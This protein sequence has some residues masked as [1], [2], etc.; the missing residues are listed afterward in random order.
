MSAIVLTEE[1]LVRRVIELNCPC[2]FE[3]LYKAY[4]NLVRAAL[5]RRLHGLSSAVVEEFAQDFWARLPEVLAS[6]D[7]NRGRLRT[8]L[9]VQA[10]WAARS[11]EAKRR[12]RHAKRQAGELPATVGDPGASRCMSAFSLESAHGPEAALDGAGARKAEATARLER[13][14]RE[15]Q[16]RPA[17][18]VGAML[19]GRSGRDIALELGLHP[20]QVSRDL[21]RARTI[22]DMQLSRHALQPAL[23]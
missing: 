7:P 1:L 23:A 22:L 6:W 21:A 19:E 18:V 14:V 4:A 16:D 20:A 2:S 15:G 10:S 12:R 11:A 13:F 8:F 9:G 5:Q 17:Y 3:L